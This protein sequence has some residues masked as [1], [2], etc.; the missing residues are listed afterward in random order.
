MK[1]MIFRESDS[2]HLINCTY[3]NIHCHFETN[4]QIPVDDIIFCRYNNLSYLRLIFVKVFL[5]NKVLVEFEIQNE[6]LSPAV[7]GHGEIVYVL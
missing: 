4:I 6:F 5:G 7:E 2:D 1:S 3:P